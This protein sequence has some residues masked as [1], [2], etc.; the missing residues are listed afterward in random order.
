MAQANA[1][2]AAQ[3]YTAATKGQNVNAMIFWLKARANWQ[4]K[5]E[6]TGPGGQAGEPKR[7]LIEFVDARAGGE[8]DPI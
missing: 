2:V 8:D 6:I 7:I 3:L 5:V 1:K 4:D